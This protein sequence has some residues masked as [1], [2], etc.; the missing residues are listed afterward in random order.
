MYH[1]TVRPLNIVCK[2]NYEDFTKLKAILQK[3]YPGFQLSYLE[4]NSWF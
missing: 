4:K 1:M 3:F 2:R